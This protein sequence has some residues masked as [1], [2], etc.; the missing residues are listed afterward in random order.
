MKNSAIAISLWLVMFMTPVI[1]PVPVT[2]VNTHGPGNDTVADT[3]ETWLDEG[4]A[5]W[6]QVED[7]PALIRFYA[8]RQLGID[9]EGGLLDAP[10]HEELVVTL[11]GSDCVIYVEMSL[12]M[13]MTTLQLQKS[14]DAFRENLTFIRYRDGEID[15]YPSRLHYFSD[16]LLTN[17]EKGLV[18]VKF[19]EEDLPVIE[20]PDFMSQ[21]RED[22]RHIADDDSLYREIS[23]MEKALADYSLRY[24]PEDEIP[25]YED[26]FETG[27][28][29][30]FVTTIDG[31]DITHTGLVRMDG[32]RAGFY[33]ASMTGAVIE[34]PNTIYEYT[35]GRDNV[36]GIV[37]ARLRSPQM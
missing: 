25:G 17:E 11:D 23:R 14:Y 10:E 19:Q 37:I 31:L 18:S 21:N 33:H 16:W 36:K 32:D 30:A 35:K 27:D 34:D 26:R 29:L 7:V 22:Y 5:Y 4:F 9:Y 1:S 15:G 6:N 2:A 13:T 8:E 3:I 24:I 20:P 12:A 28:V